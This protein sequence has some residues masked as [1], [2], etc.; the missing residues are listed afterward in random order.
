MPRTTLALTS[1][2]S[3]EL[4][5]KL[6]GRTDFA[7]YA[8]GAKTLEN[9]L[10]HPQ[11]SATRRV[12]TKFI[13]EVKTSSK[14]TRLIPFEFS[15]VQTYIL[16]FG[17]QYMRVY[18]DQGQV[19]DSGS[20]FEISTPYLEAELFE[21]KF[22]QS[23]DVMYITHP[24]HEVE[25]LSR[26]GHTNWTLTDVDFTDGPYLSPNS[27]TTTL[28]PA[29]AAVATGVNFTA[30]AVTGINNGDGFQTT[31]VGRLISF[32]SGI[33]KVTSR[34][35]TTVVV[36]EILTAFTNTDAK[37]DWKLGAFSDTTGHPS[38]V[39]FFEQRLVFAGTTNEPQTLY[40]SKSGDYENMTAGTN[41]DDA[42]IYTIASNQVNR[43]RYLKA[44][45][46][47]IVGTTG[48]EFTVSAD[49][50]DAAI[51]P[52]NIVIKKQ[53]SYG[54]ANVDA[55]PAGNAVLFLQK[56]K[57]KIRELSYNFDTDGYV[58]PDLTI[59]NDIVTKSGI[60]EMSY[61]QEPDSILW[62]VRDDGVLAGLTYQRSENVIAWHRHILGGKFGEATITVTDFANIADG[63]KIVFTKSDGTTTT[64]T[65]ATSATSGKFH[66][67]SSNNQ[68]ATN[69]KTLIDADA[70]FTATVSTNTVTIKE[71]T[72]QAS[73]FLTISSGDT[74]RLAS[75]DEAHAVV[76]SAASIS[77]T[78][79]ED[80]FYVIVKRTINGSTKRFVEVFAN[81]DFDEN[82]ATDFKFLD[83]H[84]I[85]DGSATS[86]LSGLSHLEG[87]TVSVLADGSTHAT[88]IV[89]SGSISLDR[90]TTKAVV[91]LAYDS[92]LQTMRIEGGA[93]EGTS[94]GKTKRISKVVLRLFE[95][96]G[97]KVG[98]TLAKLETV[99]FRTTSSD[100]SA[101]VD[102][103]LAGDR[104]I[105]FRDDYNSD[106]F[107]FIKQDQPLPLSVLAIY[108][109]VVTSDG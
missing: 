5:A 87:Q 64:F 25:K 51:T 106:G 97:V 107:I 96:V 24:N 20:A 6:D 34:T 53:S 100:L 86:T 77:G 85:Y 13:A 72:P 101:P 43:I 70:D 26:T 38:C 50:T 75:T 88:K 83:S 62:C 32:N 7:K 19:L 66:S 78:L 69:L 17:D 61:Q 93:A 84:L 27:T 68:T 90:S 28:T 4:G 108:P 81:F 46:T 48:G 60:N 49:G 15:T 55:I 91:G 1:F 40:F 8:T 105:E 94:Q 74:T 9:F 10:I 2:V 22:A 71:T 102:T 21:L 73:G 109:T 58:A 45:R 31:D 65:S 56:A 11:G 59:L 76:E 12:G 30:S 3:G 14:K 63:T 23:A 79:T 54:T 57:R 44:Q 80:E 29:S 104:E 39:S 89:S 98:P 37:T 33:A 47:L 95:T 36:C 67:T 42:M 82:D 99:P 18:K 103:L 52:S 41:A 16:E 35:S 92:V